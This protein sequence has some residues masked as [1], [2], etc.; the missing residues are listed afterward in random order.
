MPD[1]HLCLHCGHDV[2]ADQFRGG[3]R[4]RV[5]IHHARKLRLKYNSGSPEKRAFNCLRLRARHDRFAFGQDCIRMSRDEAL[6]FL[7]DEQLHDFKRWSLMPRDPSRVL[8]ADNAVLV[9]NF[10][11]HYLMCQ[12]HTGRCLLA[13]KEHLEFLLSNPGK[14]A[15]P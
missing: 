5:C 2:P 7:S 11:R 1:P 12:W 14:E 6:A 3:I 9:T 8:S 15:A 10:Q 13:Y 4:A